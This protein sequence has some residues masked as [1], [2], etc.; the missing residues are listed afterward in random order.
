LEQ[1]D[2]VKAATGAYAPGFWRTSLYVLVL[3]YVDELPEELLLDELVAV[4]P[5]ELLVEFS[6]GDIVLTLEFE[7]LLLFC[8]FALEVLLLVDPLEETFWFDVF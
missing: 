2:V 3:S 5:V 4:P 8:E 7:F 6:T 1:G